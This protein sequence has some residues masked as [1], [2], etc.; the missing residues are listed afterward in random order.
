MREGA[1]ADIKGDKEHEGADLSGGAQC[2][3]PK[4][5]SFSTERYLGPWI[6]YRIQE[7]LLKRDT[8]SLFPEW[9]ITTPN[10]DL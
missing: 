1:R 9:G 4:I 10:L 6:G 8:T 3:C 2:L 7:R 5:G